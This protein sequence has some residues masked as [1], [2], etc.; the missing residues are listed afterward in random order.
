MEL[1]P[2]KNDGLLGCL[3]I[4]IVVIVAGWILASIGS[5]DDNKSSN[6]LQEA[7]DYFEYSLKKDKNDGDDY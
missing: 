2:K 5:S 7:Q 3:I 4:I 6:D 1:E